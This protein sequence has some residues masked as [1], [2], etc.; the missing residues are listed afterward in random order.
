MLPAMKKQM[1]IWHRYL[2][3][4]LSGIMAV[5]AISGVVLI[6]RD[7]DFLKVE[8]QI[9]R[10]LKPG[11]DEVS[12]GQALRIRGLRAI[13]ESTSQI[14]FA[15]GTYDKETGSVAYTSKQLPLVLKKMTE[16]H[17]ANSKQPLFYLNIFFGGSLLFFV[18]SSF[19]M[20]LPSSKIFRRGIYVALAGLVLTIVMVYL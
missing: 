16:M 8:K 14:V 4:F 13:E 5:Y 3:F 18:L 15:Q 9:E 12:L 7:T 17:K 2:G 10:E 19:L 11:L 20:F 6:F 1:R